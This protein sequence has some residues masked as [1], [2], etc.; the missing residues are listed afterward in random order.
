MHIDSL[1]GERF[2]RNVFVCLFGSRAMFVNVR[3]VVR[4]FKM[5]EMSKCFFFC[6][7]R[8]HGTFG[9]WFNCRQ[10]ADLEGVCCFHGRESKTEL[11][12]GSDAAENISRAPLLAHH[13]HHHPPGGRQQV[14]LRILRCV[15]AL[16][17]LRNSPCSFH[18]GICWTW[19]RSWRRPGFETELSCSRG[20]RP[21]QTPK[22]LEAPETLAGGKRGCKRRQERGANYLISNLLPWL[23]IDYL[24]PIYHCLILT[25]KAARDRLAT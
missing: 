10:L 22:P 24:V 14:Y 25:N 23:C 9:F 5:L 17:E 6:R 2:W 16:P 8:L 7:Y 21:L 19:R 20:C 13:H 11:S 12:L 15:A 18:Q 3:A 1:F 4:Y